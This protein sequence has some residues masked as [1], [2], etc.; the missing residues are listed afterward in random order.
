M[1][2]LYFTLHTLMCTL[3]CTYLSSGQYRVTTLVKVRFEG[4]FR[5]VPS[6]YPVTINNHYIE[7]PTWYIVCGTGH[8]TN[9][10][11]VRIPCKGISDYYK[12]WA[13]QSTCPTSC[14]SFIGF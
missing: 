14:I 5:L 9:K 13:G 1:F 6:Y 2:A 7:Y 10:A 11:T 4:R 8:K 12:K 3:Q